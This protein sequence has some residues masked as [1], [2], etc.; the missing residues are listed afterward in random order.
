V[1]EASIEDLPARERQWHR[2]HRR[3]LAAATAEFE[4]VG[5]GAARVEHIC[6]AAAVTRPTFYAHFPTKDDVLVELQREA[7]AAVAEAMTARLAAAGSLRDV[8]DAL[9]DGIFASTGQMSGR[10]RREVLSMSVRKQSIADWEGTALHGAL[11]RALSEARESGEI[12][13]S[14]PP[15]AVA[16]CI[17]MVLLGF[18]VSDPESLERNRSEAREFLHVLVSGLRNPRNSLA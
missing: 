14:H 4:R 16:R 8:V 15:N 2:T 10:M 1:T 9:S 5:V 12:D 7:A 6:R 17:M 18:L 11:L 3:I 13:G